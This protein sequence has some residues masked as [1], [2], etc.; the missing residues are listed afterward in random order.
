MKLTRLPIL[1][2]ASAI[3]LLISMPACTREARKERSIKAAAELYQKGDYQAAEIEIKNALKADPGSARAIKQFGLIR[4]GQGAHYEAAGI[5]TQAQ[6]MMPNDNEVA[7]ALARSLFSLGFVSDSR[8]VLLEL[9]DRDPSNGPALIALSDTSLTPEW[10]DEFE[11]RLK[12]AG[13]KTVET[14]IAEALSKLRRGMVVEGSALV[15]EV[16][17]EA[18]G[19]ARAHALKAS[20]LA[21]RK[22]VEPALAEMKLAADAGGAR[23]PETIGYA[24]MLMVNGRKD[25][26]VA[27]LEK[28]SGQAPDYLPAWTTLGQIALDAKDDEKATEYFVKVIGRDP[29]EAVSVVALADIWMR[30]GQPDKA[31]DIMETLTASLPSRPAL[32]LLLTKCYLAAQNVPKAAAALDRVLENEAT[33]S[34]ASVLR[35]Q[36]FLKEGNS[37]EGVRLLEGVRSRDAK[38][39]A[40][41]DLLIEAYRVTG[42]NKEAVALLREK[43]GL[44][45]ND[46]QSQLELGQLLSAMGKDDE[47]KS[48]FNEALET[49]SD[50]LPAVCNLASLDMK[51]GKP[52]EAMRKIDAYL[53]DHPDSSE[54]LTFKA[55]L[56]LAEKK[57]D[58]AVELLKEAIKLK[59]DNKSAYL[60]LLGTQQG[61]GSLAILDDYLKVFPDDSQARLSRGFLLQ[62]LGRPDGARTAFQSLIDD[63]K[64]LAA[65]HNNLAALES[66]VGNNLQSA[67][68]HARE[69]RLLDPGQPAI[70]DTL[71]W[72]EWQLGNYPVALQLLSEANAGIPNSPELLYH[73]GMAQYSMGQSADATASLTE[74]TAAEAD[75]PGK[76]KA[77]DQLAVLKDA[78]SASL[79]ELEKRVGEYPKDVLSRMRLAELQAKAGKNQE[80]FDSY[81]TLIDANPALAAAWIGQARLLA[82]PLNSPEKALATA[83][84]AREL[85]PTDAHALAALGSAKLRNGN[86]EEAYGLLKDAASQLTDDAAV[87]RDQA[88]AAYSLGRIEEARGVMQRVSK[89]DVLEAA[90]ATTF[91]IFTD[92]DAAQ[93]SDI[94]VEIEKALAKDSTNVPALMLQAQLATAAGK[95]PETTYLEVLKLQP[96]FDPARV[97]LASYY[98]EDPAKLDEALKLATKA[99]ASMPDDADLTRVLAMVRFRKGEMKYAAQ[100][101]SEL[102]IMRPL[103]PDEALVRGLAFAGSNEPEKA[104][105]ALNEAL[106]AGL[107]DADA[108]K[109]KEALA[110]L[111]AVEGKK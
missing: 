50:S 4:S 83:A 110:G 71:G 11:A 3:L 56:L 77:L 66:T 63:G 100:L 107:S 10:S 72:I 45:S 94:T 111:D 97:R 78:G 84:K 92:P 1:R 15:D 86:H 46:P 39:V 48:I 85:A 103:T 30:G 37:S 17:K 18:P 88:L 47:A 40:A 55:G 36:I 20:I 7:V 62:H 67:A 6:R 57:S 52:E 33:N 80:A 99:R 25:E 38:N 44:D 31:V 59:P 81:Q 5:L 51:Q 54:A 23:S 65:A 12:N 104:K 58:E 22:E 26:A 109:A 29:A 60:V 74:A 9:L 96:L 64:E 43:T 73:L 8:K 19:M 13:Q 98:L 28:S 42:R 34:E 70:A 14:R 95:S 32:D 49:F 41:R 91:L 16:L 90:E 105:E 21:S 68:D 75:F 79:E 101:L 76:D 82:G 108:A 89:M 69:A 93:S 27:V 106:K 35:A 87:L 2:M 24:R 61:D 53:A 102:A